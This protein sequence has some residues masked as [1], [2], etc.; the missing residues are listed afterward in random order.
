MRARVGEFGGRR[1]CER[2]EGNTASANSQMFFVL[3]GSMVGIPLKPSAD[4]RGNC[5][6]DLQRKTPG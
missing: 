2:V 5:V 3:V 4:H 1:G 6:Y